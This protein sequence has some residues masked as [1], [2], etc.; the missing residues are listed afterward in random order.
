MLLSFLGVAVLS[1]LGDSLRAIFLV[2]TLLTILSP[3]LCQGPLSLRCRRLPVEL[4][5]EAWSSSVGCS[6]SFC[7][8]SRAVMVPTCCKEKFEEKF[9]QGGV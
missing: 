7:Q 6:L 8:L 1:Y 4:P 2:L 3:R 5:A 9:L